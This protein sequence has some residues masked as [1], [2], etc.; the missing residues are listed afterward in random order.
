MQRTPLN[1]NLRS[2]Y[3]S[4]PNYSAPSSNFN[5]RPPP[6]ERGVLTREFHHDHREDHPRNDRPGKHLARR[7]A[8]RRPRRRGSRRGPAVFRPPTQGP[9][10]P[11]RCWQVP[12]DA[13]RE[14]TT[15]AI[16]LA[17]QVES[18][19]YRLSGES[20]TLV[21]LISAVLGGFSIVAIVQIQYRRNRI[22]DIR[23]TWYDTPP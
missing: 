6:H 20:F 19:L 17:Q 23:T 2:Q 21:N 16:A 5:P 13:L 15:P 3:R 9:P 7:R 14:T 4:V 1:K 12:T 22:K 11:G 10:P 18:F 8:R